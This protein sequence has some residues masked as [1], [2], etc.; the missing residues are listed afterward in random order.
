MDEIG[1]IFGWVSWI[2]VICAWTL[3]CIIIMKGIFKIINQEEIK[4]ETN[5]SKTR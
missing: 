4:G 1:S 2:I 5:E 3:I